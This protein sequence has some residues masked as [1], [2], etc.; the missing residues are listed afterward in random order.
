MDA[1][2]QR[3]AGELAKGSR[4]VA[5]GFLLWLSGNEPEPMRIRGTSICLERS[6]KKGKKGEQIRQ[7]VVQA[8]AV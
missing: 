7:M 4:A 1:V 6:P 5:R 8:L 2:V 3:L